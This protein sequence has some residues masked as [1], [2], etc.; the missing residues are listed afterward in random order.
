MPSGPLEALARLAHPVEQL[1]NLVQ[2]DEARGARERVPGVRVRVDVLGAELPHLLETVAIEE[3]RRERQAAAERL[4]D[5]EHVRDFLAGPHLADPAEPREDRVDDE[6]RPRLV[7]AAAKRLEEAVRRDARPG[8]ALHRLDDHAAGVLG[9]RSGILAVRAPVHRPGQPRRERLAELLEAGRGERE[10]TRCRGR[11]RRTRRCPAARSR[12]APSAARSRLRPRRS[13]R[14]SPAVAAPR[15]GARSPRRRPGLRAR[16][17]PPAHA[18]PRGC[19]GCDGR[20][21]R[22][23][24][25]RSGRAAHA[26]RRA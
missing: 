16:A 21:P 10:Q 17:R 25:R 2:H 12:A 5:A 7:A 13:R 15:A 18:T 3:R 9:Q 8:S 1:R 24:S 14:A 11:R 23:R 6:Q 26:R 20:A 22:R 19:A 4:A